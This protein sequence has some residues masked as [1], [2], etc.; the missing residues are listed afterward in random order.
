MSHNQNKQHNLITNEKIN[1]IVILATIIMNEK[2]TVG[3]REHIQLASGY[4]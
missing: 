4:L 1:I 3:G 2:E